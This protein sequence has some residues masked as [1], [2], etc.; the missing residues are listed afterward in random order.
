RPILDITHPAPANPAGL[1]FRS[2][3]DLSAEPA[4]QPV[5]KGLYDSLGDKYIAYDGSPPSSLVAAGPVI[6]GD[7]VVGGILVATSLQ[8]VLM[9]M[10]SK[11][12]SEVILID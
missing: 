4:V 2:G 3:T 5:L 10:Q 8:A 9:K 11:S 1:V 7:R 6:F 12:H